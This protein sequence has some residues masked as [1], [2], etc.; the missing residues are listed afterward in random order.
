MSVL[1]KMALLRE[2]MEMCKA[3]QRPEGDPRPGE[4]R[5]Q[6]FQGPAGSPPPG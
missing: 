3:K 1:E 2:K 4:R 5:G 6:C